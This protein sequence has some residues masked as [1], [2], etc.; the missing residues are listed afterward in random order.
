MSQRLTIDVTANDVAMASSELVPVGNY[1][2]IIDDVE[3]T[4]P[5]SGDNVGKPMYRVKFKIDG[6]PQNGRVATSQVCLWDGALISFFQLM[7][8]IGKKIEPGKMEVPLPSELIGKKVAIRIKHESYNDEMRYK[9]GRIMARK[10]G[11]A[12][13]KSAASVSGKRSGAKRVAFGTQAPKDDAEAAENDD[14]GEG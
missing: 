8:A 13:V 7:E 14:D 4:S 1:D 10:G 11:G 9:V 5:K 3:Q 6:G 12:G 2:A